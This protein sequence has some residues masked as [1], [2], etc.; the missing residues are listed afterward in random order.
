MTSGRSTRPCPPLVRPDY[1]TRDLLE[2]GT[3]DREELDLQLPNRRSQSRAYQK[4]ADLAFR[5]DFWRGENASLKDKIA[6]L[7]DPQEQ[8]PN[9]AV[10]LLDFISQVEGNL[11]ERETDVARIRS[12]FEETRK[13][14]PTFL[15]VCVERDRRH[16]FDLVAN[17]L[18]VSN[19]QREF[20]S[21]PDLEDQNGDLME[22]I[23][24]QDEELRSLQA[25][26][27]FH[28][29]LQHQGLPEL[30][31][32]SLRNGQ[33]PE[34]LVGVAPTQ[35]DERLLKKRILQAELKQLIA[36]RKQLTVSRKMKVMRGRIARLKEKAAVKIQSV[37]RGFLV[38]VKQRRSRSLSPREIHE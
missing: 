2:V 21:A 9:S 38:R 32:T 34:K 18:L 3:L 14:K 37:V 8:P 26:I 19:G 35:S 36:E 10:Q 12:Q 4:V 31:L 23:R 6:A 27:M 33:S 5:I 20:F 15:E 24:R 16:P 11:R 1:P 7:S 28:M 30:T 17:S 22:L 25:R 13:P 29:K